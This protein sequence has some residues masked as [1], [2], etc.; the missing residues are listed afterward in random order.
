MTYIYVYKLLRQELPN[1]NRPTPMINTDPNTPLISRI[2]Y[3]MFMQT[4]SDELNSS[5]ISHNMHSTQIHHHNPYNTFRPQI[6]QFIY[7]KLSIT[8]K[9]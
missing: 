5:N 2:H 1:L 9:L 8:T 3:Q 4:T 7:Q 6:Q